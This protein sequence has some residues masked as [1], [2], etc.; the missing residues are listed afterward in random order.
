M[1]DGDHM[2]GGQ[3]SD[4][5]PATGDA[6]RR[7]RLANDRTYLAWGRTS[8]A[9]FALALAVGRIVPGLDRSVSRWQFVVIGCAYATLGVMSVLYGLHRHRVVQDAV[10]TGGYADTS[11]TLLA[12]LSGLTALV[13]VATFVVLVFD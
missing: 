8:L 5:A 13:G 12:V 3:G 1:A 4:A 7:V 11:A 6:G 9:F 2:P 10:V